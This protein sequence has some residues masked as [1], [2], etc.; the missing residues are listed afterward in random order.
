[1]DKLHNNS[2]L[3]NISSGGHSFNYFY[4]EITNYNDNDLSNEIQNFMD[5]NI[6][7]YVA[8]RKK[9]EIYCFFY[10]KKWWN[11]RINLND[12]EEIS[13][14]GL[15]YDRDLIAL[16]AYRLDENKNYIKKILIYNKKEIMYEKEEILN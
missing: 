6:V 1:M 2:I 11:R 3:E 5:N 10:P 15:I 12:T 7:S 9:A 8:K 13:D 16:V 4:Y 14:N